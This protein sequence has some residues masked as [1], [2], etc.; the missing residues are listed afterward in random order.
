[1][2]PVLWLILIGVLVV[3]LPFAADILC[4]LFPQLGVR[5]MTQKAVTAILVFCVTMLFFLAMKQFCEMVAPRTDTPSLH[6]ALVIWLWLNTVSNYMGA[7]FVKSDAVLAKQQT[8]ESPDESSSEQSDSDQSSV[9]TCSDED[10]S[11]ADKQYVP[12]EGTSTTRGFPLSVRSRMA[13][14]SVPG[15]DLDLPAVEECDRCRRLRFPGTHHCS[16]CDCCVTMMDHHCPFTRNCVSKHNFAHFY[17]FLLYCT[18]GLV[19]A[20][21]M[22]YRDFDVC[23]V[24]DDFEQAEQQLREGGVRVHWTCRQLGSRSLVFLPVVVLA[25]MMSSFLLFHSILLFVFDSTTVD[26]F[27]QWQ[28]FAARDLQ[29]MGRALRERNRF[30]VPCRRKLLFTWPAWHYVVPFCGQF[31]GVLFERLKHNPHPSQWRRSLNTEY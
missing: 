26:F 11:A 25:M 21:C 17:L 7:V 10:M 3:Q 28:G 29:R 30:F 14:N 15:T 2:D 20:A 19:Y 4:G 12:N 31:G 18:A 13:N 9:S 6:Y 8:C 27:G 5:R 1:M 22:T 16:V 23:W 24:S